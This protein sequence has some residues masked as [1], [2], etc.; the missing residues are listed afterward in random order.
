MMKI[1]MFLIC[2][3]IRHKLGEDMARW[4][5]LLD[6]NEDLVRTEECL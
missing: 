1:I 2:N 4:T 5:V 3:S 6:E